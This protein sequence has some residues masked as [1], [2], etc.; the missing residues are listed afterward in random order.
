MEVTTVKMPP[1]HDLLTIEEYAKKVGKT[2]RTV[3]NWIA[4]KKL[5]TH[6]MFGKTLIN[7]YDRPKD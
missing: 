1:A 7:K 4:T 5:E 6:E 2:S 3:Y